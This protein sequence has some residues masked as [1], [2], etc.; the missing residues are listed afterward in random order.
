MGRTS[1]LVDTS[2]IDLDGSMG[3]IINNFVRSKLSKTQNQ[4]I[5]S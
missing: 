5:L 2:G 3:S 4:T 1:R